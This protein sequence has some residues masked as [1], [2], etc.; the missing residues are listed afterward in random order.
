ML[1]KTRKRSLLFQERRR[2]ASPL[3]GG[4]QEVSP[5]IDKAG[6]CTIRRL[7][8]KDQS[9]LASTDKENQSPGLKEES[10]SSPFD[11][12]NKSPS[13]EATD[14]TPVITMKSKSH[15]RRCSSPLRD[16]KLGNSG[17]RSTSPLAE[18]ENNVGP[19]GKVKL[20]GVK[21][22]NGISEHHCKSVIEKKN[23]SPL[24]ERN[25]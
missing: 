17:Q 11:I 10:A 2:S 19:E 14:L 7:S 25:Q 13:F 3:S 4:L 22:T 5:T 15:I 24:T 8:E 16:I 12:E 21:H 6:Q 18:L 9:P 20:D 23:A 1:K